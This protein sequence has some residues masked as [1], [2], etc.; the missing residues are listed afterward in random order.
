M[1]ASL[2]PVACASGINDTRSSNGKPAQ[3][4]ISLVY[5]TMNDRPSVS[6]GV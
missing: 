5:F 6:N 4:S 1:C 2:L 3:K